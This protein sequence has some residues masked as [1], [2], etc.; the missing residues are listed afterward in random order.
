MPDVGLRLLPRLADRP[1][2][3]QPRDP[4]HILAD[5]SVELFVSSPLWLSIESAGPKEARMVE[6]PLVRPSDT[7]LGPS[8]LMGQVAY[9]VSTSCRV[10]LEGMPFRPHRAITPLMISNRGRDRLTFERIAVPIPN[11]TSYRDQ[12]GQVWTESLE[13]TRRGSGPGSTETEV[14]PGPPRYAR[15]GEVIARPREDPES[16]I[17]RVF[18]ALV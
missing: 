4:F 6:Y 12:Q 8:T 17:L 11:L 9:S 3:V 7:W 1:I 16:G 15:D 14:V 18:D 13:V 10:D 5:T 2:V